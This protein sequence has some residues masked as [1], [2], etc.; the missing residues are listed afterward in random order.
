MKSMRSIVF[1]M[2]LC[3]VLLRGDAAGQTGG[4]AALARNVR[5]SPSYDGKN[6]KVEVSNQGDRTLMFSPNLHV[7]P[8]FIPKGDET[9][10]VATTDT[11]MVYARF[12]LANDVPPSICYPQ[13]GIEQRPI[14]VEPG[15]SLNVTL[16]AGTGFPEFAAYVKTINLIWIY[17]GLAISSVSI[18]K[19]R[20]GWQV[21]H[22]KGHDSPD[23]SK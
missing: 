11:V 7:V 8:P 17:N 2:F 10:M 12:E 23:T 5:V 21:L 20:D 19:V 4:L 6:I 1:Y 18:G 15:K 14:K 16:V 9:K 3:V 22:P 13:G